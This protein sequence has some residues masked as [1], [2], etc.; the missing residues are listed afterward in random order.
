MNRLKKKNFQRSSKLIIH[1]KLY[2]FIIELIFIYLN[3]S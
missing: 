2:V 3:V 1:G